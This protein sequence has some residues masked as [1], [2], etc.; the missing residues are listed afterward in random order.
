MDNRVLVRFWGV[1]G[2]VPSPLTAHDVARKKLKILEDYVAAMRS[3]RY[4][5]MPTPQSFLAEQE[6]E[7]PSTYGGNTSCVEVRY[8]NDIVILDMGTGL[9]PLGNTLFPEMFARKGLEAY[10]VL[11]HVH[12]DHI[13][14]LPFFG[15]LYVNKAIGISNR[16]TFLGGVGWQSTAEICLKGQMDPPTFPVAWKEI[17]KMTDNITYDDMWDGKS[18]KLGQ[19]T[20]R[21]GKLNHPQETYGSRLLFPNGKIV[22]Y[23]TD[24]EPHDPACPY[25]RLVSLAR[26]A[27]V[28]ITD[29]QYTK[30]QY[31]GAKEEGGV[32]RHGWGHSYPEAIAAMACEANVKTIV[33]FHHDPA[34]SDEKIKQME[35]YTQK[36]ISSKGGKSKVVAAWEGLE[37][38]L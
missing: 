19:A 14:G 12:W 10:F 3:G 29:C 24:H 21:F 22:V 25:P 9:R 2:S 4:S 7:T 15:P 28:V 5:P 20:A 17:E 16:W 8:E 34:S 30:G 36:L 32:P 33:L 1:R 38:N 23:A 27:D 26:D 13:Q 35:Q 6:R 37:L 18:V 31:E 11:S